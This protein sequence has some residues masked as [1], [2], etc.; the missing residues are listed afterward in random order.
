MYLLARHSN[1]SFCPP[2]PIYSIGATFEAKNEQLYLVCDSPF[3][4]LFNA[5]LPFFKN[6]FTKYISP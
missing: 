1:P 5:A 3:I 4:W 2:P 6:V